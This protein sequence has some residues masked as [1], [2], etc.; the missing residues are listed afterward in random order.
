MQH[1]IEVIKAALE[2]E[3]VIADFPAPWVDLYSLREH[4]IARAREA[5]SK[6]VSWRGFHV[7]GAALAWN[8]SGRIMEERCKIY[9]GANF[10]PTR[11][12]E[13]VCAEKNILEKIRRDRTFRTQQI[14]GLFLAAEAR[15]EPD[16]VS[17]K[18]SRTLPLCHKCRHDMAKSG[19]M[20]KDSVVLSIRGD[21]V[22]EIDTFE[23]M[24]K[25]HCSLHLLAD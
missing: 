24:L 14:V 1:G 13:T 22:F 8:G 23:G 19:L 15:E 16:V 10:K 17:G 2:G 12:V 7:G 11:E 3:L 20:R 21:D 6:A 5:L 18:V 25:E 9:T 4:L